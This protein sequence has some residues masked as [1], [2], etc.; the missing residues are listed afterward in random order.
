MIKAI[1]FN[2]EEK[3]KS[4][5]RSVKD[6]CQGRLSRARLQVYNQFAEELAQQGFGAQEEERTAWQCPACEARKL[7]YRLLPIV[8][9]A[10]PPAA[11]LRR[12]CQRCPLVV[13]ANQL[14]WFLFLGIL[15]LFRFLFLLFCFF[16]DFCLFRLG[17][18]R[19]VLNSC[20]GY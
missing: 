4:Q 17:C 16:L 19:V 6:F 9:P 3:N 14:F 2:R 5:S 11:L 15:I 12:P 10:A 8:A 13:S 1:R 20:H 7:D 18:Y